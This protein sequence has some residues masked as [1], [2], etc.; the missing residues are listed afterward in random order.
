MGN[1]LSKGVIFAIGLLMLAL[2][3]LAHHSFVAEFDGDRKFVVTGVLTKVQWTNPH[4]AL[5]VD[6]KDEAG[7][8]VTY[9][10]A[11]GPPSTLHKAGVRQD[12]FKIGETVTITASPGQGRNQAP[13]LA[14]DDQVSRWARVR[15]PE[16]LRIKKLTCE[17]WSRPALLGIHE[18]SVAMRY[19]SSIFNKV[20][21]IGASLASAMLFF[22]ASAAAQS[23]TPLTPDGHPN[24]SG[25]WV[26][27]AGAVWGP[28]CLKDR[29]MDLQ[30]FEVGLDQGK[31]A[32]C[33]D[34]SCQAA[35]Q[36]S[37]TPAFLPKVREI[38]KTEFAGTTPLDPVTQCKPLGI[39]RAKSPTF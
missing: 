27:N 24:L 34:D 16:R 4:I 20:V 2:P 37:Y 36:P 3:A 26:N 28:L 7:K 12:D 18:G 1:R 31:E 35:D 10:F 30:L 6:G 15:V 29:R 22:S 8:P 25:Y 5:F 9:M 32:L 11:S 13:R 14:A 38:A 39:P 17:I 23:K 33:T 19:R 21:F